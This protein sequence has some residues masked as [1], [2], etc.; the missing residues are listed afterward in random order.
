MKQRMTTNNL[1]DENT[2]LKTRLQMIENTLQRKDKLIDDLIQAQEANYGMP[3]N[4]RSV[5]SVKGEQTHLILNLKKKIRDLISE[6]QVINEDVERLKRN[7]RSTKL[8]EVEAEVKIYMEE[9]ARLRHQLEEVIKSKD[10]FADPQ[11]IKM[12]EEKFQ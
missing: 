1:K 2:R 7:I 4:K 10:T 9:C 12:I 6:K 3:N 11:E 5:P 8:T